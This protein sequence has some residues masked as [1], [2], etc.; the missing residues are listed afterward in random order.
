VTEGGNPTRRAL[1]TGGTGFTGSAL[2]KRLRERGLDVRVL[3][4]QKG[5][6]FDELSRL[7]ADIRIGSVTDYE[8]VKKAVHGCSVIFHLAAAFRTINVSKSLYWDV[9]V[10]G[11]V[12]MAKAS[13][14]E[15]V[16][17]F[18]YCSTEGVHGHV[19]RPPA[20]ENGPINP[21]DYY[22][23]TK[24][25]GER[26]LQP[27]VE[28]GLPSVI[29]R[30]TAI[31]GPGDPERFYMIYRRVL[32]GTFPMFGDG[33]TW[34]HPVYIDNLVQAFELAMDRREAIGQAYLIG[35][36]S[37]CSIE[38]LVRK[39]AKSLNVDVKIPHLPFWLIWLPSVLCEAVCKPLRIKPP[40]FPRRADWFRKTRAFDISKAKRELG[41][42]PH[43]DLDEGLRRTAD[44]Y[45]REGMLGEPGG[46]S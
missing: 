8:Q 22:E 34:Y 12:N 13:L 9:N 33:S 31:Y 28:K 4:N 21:Q 19:E 37:Y 20:D 17:R 44:W 2:V 18:V 43:V 6:F 25:E 40:L 14:E 5:I 27:F 35:D 32:T 16:D 36:E 41:Y 15:G 11:V 39:T 45:R 1:V 3:D 23:Y 7:G 42:A 29:L 30:P 26:A 38:D 10:N 24:W 46:P